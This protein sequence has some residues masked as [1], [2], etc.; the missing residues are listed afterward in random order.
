[1]L[2]I[3]LINPALERVSI[4]CD[5]GQQWTV[6]TV[7][8]WARFGL[9]PPDADGNLGAH[10]T[11][12]QAWY[13]DGVLTVTTGEITW[14]L[15]I[16]NSAPEITQ[17]M[18]A[19]GGIV[20][21]VTTA[22]DPAAM[23]DAAPLNRVAATRDAACGYITFDTTTP[24]PGRPDLDPRLEDGIHH[25]PGDVLSELPVVRYRGPTYDPATG[26]FEYGIGPDGR[27]SWELHAPG[28]PVHNGLIVGPPKSGKTNSLTIIVIEAAQSGRFVPM[29][30]DPQN[31]NEHRDGIGKALGQGRFAHDLAGTIG[32]LHALDRMIDYRR[33]TGGFNTPTE[34]LPGVLLLLEDAHT[35]FCDPD[36]ATLGERIVTEGPPV[37]V[38]IVATAETIDRAAFAGNLNL[39]MRLGRTNGQ[40]F[41]DR[42]LAQM[43]VYRSHHHST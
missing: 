16:T 13:Q 3:L 43:Q 7:T 21:V 2:P 31:S 20:V 14:T 9:R 8:D 32:L 42:A 33:E 38:G 41:S 6:T 26:T 28:G 5:A 39:I 22:L 24:P 29:L 11:T 34:E 12:M 37:C 27:V 19:L 23:T 15:P 18:T 10:S 30:A 40:F 36:L 35:V 17:A 25:S 1:M 4:S